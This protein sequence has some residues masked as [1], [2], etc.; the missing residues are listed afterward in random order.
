MWQR[1]GGYE[2]D[3]NRKTAIWLE[4]RI[5]SYGGYRTVRKSTECLIKLQIFEAN[6]L[7]DVA[8]GQMIGFLPHGRD[9]EETE[10]VVQ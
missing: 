7:S 5:I 3:T 2:V 4:K 1:D 9:D 8:W 6:V 10:W